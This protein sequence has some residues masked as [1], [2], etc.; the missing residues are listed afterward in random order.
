MNKTVTINLSGI[1]FHID[2]NAFELLRKY[3]DTLKLHFSGTQGREEIIADIENRMAE[4]FSEKAG[5]AKNVI[6]LADVQSVIDMMGRP[7]QVAGEEETASQPGSS[8]YGPLRKRLFR[9]SD[10]KILG[11]V[12][13]GI[14]AY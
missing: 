13:S 14:G 12:C 10:D 8:H 2:E 3:L 7:E 1:V 11:G 4:M 6:M 5:D 9:N